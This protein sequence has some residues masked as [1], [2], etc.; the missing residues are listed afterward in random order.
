MGYTTASL[1]ESSLRATASFSSSTTPTLETVNGWIEEVDSHIDGLANRV[2]DVKGYSELFHFGGEAYLF[3]RNT[4][5]VDV[6]SVEYNISSDGTAP[7][8][9]TLTENVDYIV[10]SVKGMIVLLST[11]R[12]Y[13]QGYNKFRVIYTAGYTVLPPRV[14]MLATK[15]VA[16]RVLDSLIY[17]NV[18]SRNDG[19]S[20]SV[21]DIRIVEPSS[22]GVG[23]YKQLQSDIASLEDGLVGGFRVLRY[24]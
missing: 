3:V 8:W 1:V 14:R 23:S 18:N 24:G 22:Y 21:G 20:V 7:S 16:L 11:V 10:D 17:S 2:F 13:S 4:P 12:S 19:G 6:T 5:L 15:L 9:V